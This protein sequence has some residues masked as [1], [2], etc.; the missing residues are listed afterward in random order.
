MVLLF[1]DFYEK[2]Y[3]V[4]CCSCLAFVWLIFFTLVVTV[5]YYLAHDAGGKFAKR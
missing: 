5:P 1:R 4:N 2:H 3:K